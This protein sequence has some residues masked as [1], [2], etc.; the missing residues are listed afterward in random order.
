M[1]IVKLKQSYS[2]TVGFQRW[3]FSYQGTVSIHKYGTG[4]D[5]E[6]IRRIHLTA[7]PRAINDPG[8]EVVMA[9]QDRD[10]WYGTTG[11]YGLFSVS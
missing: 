9:V 4:A 3:Y 10:I 6:C 7:V 5:I 8:T 2:R 11:N 1:K